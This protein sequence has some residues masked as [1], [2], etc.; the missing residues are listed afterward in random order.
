MNQSTNYTWIFNLNIWGKLGSPWGPI[1][2][3]L[4]GPLSFETVTLF[5]L[6][7]NTN[8]I[9]FK[10]SNSWFEVKNEPLFYE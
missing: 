10:S 7:Q 2:A 9:I 5:K 4:N 8:P 3:I 1:L 6:W